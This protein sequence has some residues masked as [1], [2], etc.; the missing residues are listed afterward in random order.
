MVHTLWPN[1]RLYSVNSSTR[2][3]T[4]LAHAVWL[5]DNVPLLLVD[6]QAFPKLKHSALRS[7][8]H[9]TVTVTQQCVMLVELWG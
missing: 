8:T 1:S 2:Q 3:G 4:F 5:S 7:A 6:V 9:H